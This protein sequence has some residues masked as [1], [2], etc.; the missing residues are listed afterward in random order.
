[1]TKIRFGAFLFF[2]CVFAVSAEVCRAQESRPPSREV[3]VLV[4]ED[5]KDL[6]VTV[7]GAYVIKLL[8]SLQVVKTGHKLQSVLVTPSAR[9]IKFGTEEWAAQ[10]F[11]LETADEK[12]LFLDRSCFRGFVDIL[13]NPS[14]LYAINHLDME[15][16]LYGVLH[17]EVSPWWPMEALKSQAVAARTYALYQVQVNHAAEYDLKSSTSSQVY[18]GST[19]ERYRT[20]KAVDITA[21]QVLT[22]QGKIFPAYFHATC[23]G[24]TAGADELWKISLPPLSGKVVCNYCRISPHYIW[25]ARIPFSNIEEKLIKN[26]R[27]IG[28]ILNVEII[29]QTPSHRVGSLRI[30]GTSGEA[31]IAAKDF[32]IWVGGDR[33]RSTNFTL[34]VRDD[35]LDLQGK[36]WGHGVGL[37]QW[38]TLGQAL[39]GRKY[40]TILKFYYPGAEITSS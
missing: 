15:S 30:T 2:L 29:S 35:S 3:R 12:D 28:Q 9:G 16:Y 32:R 11:R 20:K 7:K 6:R 13:K 25:R 18:G 37:C 39:L 14:G 33:M 27:N 23:A 22:Y 31:V 19:T 24:L 21:G 26:G 1:M 8:P 10:G 34:T 4:A 40:D 38:G 5:Q 36:G 17:H